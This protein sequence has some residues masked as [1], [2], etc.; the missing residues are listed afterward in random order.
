[1]LQYEIMICLQIKQWQNIINYMPNASVS[2]KRARCTPNR[3]IV[4]NTN[5]LKVYVDD[6]D[7]RGCACVCLH[8]Y[9]H[10]EF[11][12]AYMKNAW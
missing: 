1:M 7:L 5:L 9:V 10:L 11:V 4:G 8:M 6:A 12:C 3:P 2:T